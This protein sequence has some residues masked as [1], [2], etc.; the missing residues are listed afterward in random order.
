[1]LTTPPCSGIIVINSDETILVQTKNGNYSFPK[2][3]KNKNETSLETAFRECREETGI[4]KTNLKI[5]D[6][7]CI[8]EYS[9]KGNIAI[10]YYVGYTISKPTEFKFDQ[11]EL[12]N[13]GWIKI[14]DALQL[15]KL[16]N[17]RKEILQQAHNRILID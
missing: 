17:R 10:R 3:K 7:Y 15:D 1:M 5:I 11:S 2:G 4:E 9:D 16:K 14:S 8:D 6:G 13:V 12:N